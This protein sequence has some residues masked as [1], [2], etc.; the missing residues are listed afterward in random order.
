MDVEIGSD[1]E[2]IYVH[3]YVNPN[4]FYH[5]NL[6]HQ[7]NIVASPITSEEN[8]QLSC[9]FSEPAITVEHANANL[10]KK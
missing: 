2:R 8:R 9:C 1:N 10:I 5:T 6:S 3:M 4:A 7:A